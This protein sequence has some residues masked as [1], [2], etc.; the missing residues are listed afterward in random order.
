MVKM[1]EFSSDGFQSMPPLYTDNLRV[2]E[3]TD[4]QNITLE[5]RIAEYRSFLETNP[6][7]RA[8]AEANR[9]I[10]HAMFELSSRLIDEAEGADRG[11]VLQ[12]T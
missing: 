8:A 11:E 4:W 2:G 9:I 6:M 5:S 3:F 7:P 10:V 12:Q 1:S